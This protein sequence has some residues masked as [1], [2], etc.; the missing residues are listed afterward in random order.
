VH[1]EHIKLIL[2]QLLSLCDIYGQIYFLNA[3]L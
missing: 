3:F 2:A 1:D